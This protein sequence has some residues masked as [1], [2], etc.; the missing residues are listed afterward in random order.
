MK[1]T[2]ENL[3]EAI[4]REESRFGAAPMFRI[5]GGGAP[6]RRRLLP[7]L[8][9]GLAGLLL[10]AGLVLTG[11]YVAH[12]GESAPAGHGT[13]HGAYWSGYPPA[14]PAPK[15]GP[16]PAGISLIWAIDAADPGRL[17][18][19]DWDGHEVGALTL[20]QNATAFVIQSP[21]GAY[22]WTEDRFLDRTGREVGVL[23]AA[24]KGQP[25]WAEDSRH[26]CGV[27]DAASHSELWTA[28][29]GVAP[30][31]VAAVGPG[32]G[33]Q[34]GDR[35]V[36]CSVSRDLAIVYRS[37]IMS[38]TDVWAVRLST[39]Q[40]V[41]HLTNL[42]CVNGVAASPDARYL[43][44]NTSAGGA[45]NAN[46]GPPTAIR[47][48]PTGG[49]LADLGTRYVAAISSSGIV[50]TGDGSQLELMSVR[51]KLLNT[52]SAPGQSYYVLQRPGGSDLLL[53]FNAQRADGSD[54]MTIVRP[55]WSRIDIGGLHQVIAN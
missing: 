17:L 20:D 10:V 4:Q 49:V 3:R 14:S 50:M 5:E 43:A 48:V 44:L 16:P 30:R 22:L 11:R 9:A 29:P 32:A 46:P 28:S 36:A 55:D 42:V 40:V 12:L 54:P 39:G 34:S 7:V 27:R 24:D 25:V 35:V 37:A 19:Y 45:C 13:H 38:V 41:T 2:R 52:F 18:A 1:L 6:A 51:G 26:V 53:A 21:D 8:A 23:P 31:D 33:G 47:D 15:L